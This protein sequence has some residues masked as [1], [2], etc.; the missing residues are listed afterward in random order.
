MNLWVLWGKTYPANEGRATRPLLCHMV[1]VAEV[2]GALW[3]T[4]LGEGLRRHIAEA[5]GCEEEEARRTVMFWASLHD[6]GK[7]SPAFQRRYEPAVPLLEKE[8]F[9]FARE[10]HSTDENAWHNLITALTLPPILETYHTP[11]PL[12]RDIA[13]GLGGHHGSWPPPNLDEILNRDHYGRNEWDAARA[14]IVE[15]LANLYLPVPLDGRLTERA[16]RQALVVLVSGL[17][18][19]ADWIGS[20]EE[21]FNGRGESHDLTAYA[22]GSAKA[23]RNALH[24]LQW[25]V[26][27]P[28]ERPAPF[29]MLFPYQPYAMQQAV[30]DLAPEL[31]GPSL[32]LIEAPT[33]SGKTESALYL[34]DYWAH[35]LQQR[36]L[37][38]AM[39]TMA[40]SNEMHGRVKKMLDA[41]YG[42]GRVTPLLIHGQAQWQGEPS[43]INIE[44]ERPT[45]EAPDGVEAMS[46]FL[47]R[48][49]GLLAPFGVGTVDQALLSVLLTRHFFVR[50]FGLSHKTVIFD[51]V[52]A[53]DTYMSTLFARLLSWLRAQGSSVV[54]LSA[55]LPASTRQAF[56]EAYGA[57]KEFDAHAASYPSVTWVS[58]ERAGCKPLPPPQDRHLV[59]ERI[60]HDMDALIRTLREA[61]CEGGCA[62][63]LC[64]TVARAQHV[65]MALRE[66]A[67]VPEEDLILFHARFPMIWRE[68]IETRVRARFGKSAAPS[69]RRG[70]VVATQVIEQSLDLDFDLMITDLAPIDLL[71]QRAGRLHRHAGRKRPAPLEEPRLILVEPENAAALPEWGSDAYIYEPYILLRTWL[72]LQGRAELALPSETQALIEAVYGEAEMEVVEPFA[73]ALAHYRENF[74]NS[75]S[76]EKSE[77]E[78]RLVLSANHFRLF[79][80]SGTNLSEEDPAVHASFQALTRW[81]GEGIT[82]VCLYARGDQIALDPEGEPID[83]EQSPNPVL[84]REFVRRAVQV[85]RPN[86]V[87]YFAR[88]KPPKGW[89]RH[90]LLRHY[91]PAIFEEGICSLEGEKDVLRLT[92]LLGLEI[93]KKDE[94]I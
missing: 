39:P 26:W 53:Y 85:Q 5:L 93:L 78:K 77:A 37:Y 34:A 44:T 49:R 20:M 38:V 84:V 15:G 30:I 33:G 16:E 3:D 10:Y 12:A 83:L 40:T 25:D 4:C 52:H 79:S 13:K 9:S 67:L 63:V 62:A 55:T 82:L 24:Y 90:S 46:W 48:K 14:Q 54:M 56:L 43:P 71:L 66:A 88:Q 2:V 60:P 61:L 64:N 68:E 65:F 36:G 6:L 23:A 91:R 76:K 47:P 35:A 31:S 19:I 69:E 58:S 32:V 51:E 89:R 21:F 42:E 18:S 81:G 29:T 11:S 92:P 17:V 41:R 7:A 57:P 72:A 80:Q 45:E 70:I 73:T 86:I 94:I 87:A 22:Q 28:P 74:E 27:Q 75:R 50:L 1:D 59:L 8:G